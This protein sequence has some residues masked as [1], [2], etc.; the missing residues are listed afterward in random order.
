VGP[1]TT[2]TFLGIEIDSMAMEVRLPQEKLA[3]LR[4]DFSSWRGRKA[5]RKRD[6][7]ALIG[8]LSHACKAVKAGRSF[9]RRFIDLS[10]VVS[11]LDYF[12]RLSTEARSDIKWWFQFS[13][14]WN[15]ISMMHRSNYAYMQAS[16]SLTS[17]ASGRWGF[18]A[19]SGPHWFMLK[20]AGPIVECHITAKEMVPIVVAAAIWGKSWRGKTIRAWC[21][22]AAVVSTINHGSSRNQDTMH[23]TRC[24]AFISAKLDI[25]FVAS[26]IKGIHNSCADALSRNNLSLFR[27]LYPQANPEPTAIP[28]ALLDLLVITKPDWI[29]KRW[30][31]LW[32]TIF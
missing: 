17:D 7:L 4:S 12:V 5:C 6:L 3:C 13:D 30:T 1:A 19:Y 23:L 10:T 31:E 26:H 28:E 14:R 18:G 29:S 20:W 27:A 11:K 21:D 25:H 8:I 15:G 24:L 9:L 22:N 2:I 32:S 16:V